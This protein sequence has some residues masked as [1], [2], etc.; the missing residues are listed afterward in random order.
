[1]GRNLL[2]LE[3]RKMLAS[4]D[5]HHDCIHIVIKERIKKTKDTIDSRKNKQRK[6]ESLNGKLVLH[7]TDKFKGE[8]IHA[9]NSLI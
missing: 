3:I 5:R 7:K 8:C 2:D 1:L 6:R 9:L 4:V